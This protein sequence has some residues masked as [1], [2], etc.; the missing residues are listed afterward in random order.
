M[1]HSKIERVVQIQTV[2]KIFC[3]STKYVFIKIRLCNDRITPKI[4]QLHKY[5]RLQLTMDKYPKFSMSLANGHIMLNSPV[6]VRSLKLSRYLVLQN[7]SAKV[8][9]FRFCAHELSK[10]R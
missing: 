6:L 7:I 3:K 5:Y 4:V 10:C 9:H 2:F 8:S 1:L